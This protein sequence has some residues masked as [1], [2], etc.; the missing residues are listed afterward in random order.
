MAHVPLPPGDTIPLQQA[1]WDRHGIEVPIVP[2][3]DRRYVRVSCHLYTRQK[4]IDRLV[5][6]LGELIDSGH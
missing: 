1:L 5:E 4:H 3:N 2:W 6:G